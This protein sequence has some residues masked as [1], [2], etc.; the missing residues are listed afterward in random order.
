MGGCRSVTAKTVQVEPPPTYPETGEGATRH[1]CGFRRQL[2]GL[3]KDGSE[4]F[5]PEEVRRIVR[6]ARLGVKGSLNVIDMLEEER[7]GEGKL[8]LT[9]SKS[10][11]NRCGRGRR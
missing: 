10:M 7:A 8:Q 1:T 3:L 2:I 5:T 4:Y 6:A 11:R 9:P